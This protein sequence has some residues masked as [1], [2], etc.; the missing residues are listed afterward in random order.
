[1][2]ARTRKTAPSVSDDMTC[3]MQATCHALRSDLRSKPLQTSHHPQSQSA[4]TIPENGRPNKK[5]KTA[6]SSAEAVPD[7]GVDDEE[8]DEDGDGDGDEEEDEDEEN[9]EDAGE[10]EDG[11]DEDEEAGD[12]LPTK[13]AVK[14]TKPAAANDAKG[15]TAVAAGGDE[16]D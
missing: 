1:M 9:E 3:P 16:E 8:G 14:V 13:T 11:G 6:P 7:N 2:P 12:D 4:N 15:A 10:G 5:Q